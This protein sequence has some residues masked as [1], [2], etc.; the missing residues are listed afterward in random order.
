MTLAIILV[1]LSC[2]LVVCWAGAAGSVWGRYAITQFI[3]GQ[4]LTIHLYVNN[5]TPVYGSAST[6]FT[7]LG[8]SGYAAITLNGGG[9][10][11]TNHVTYDDG[12][13]ANVTFT[14]TPSSSPDVVY[15]YYVLDGSS[16][17]VFGELFSDGPYTFPAMTPASLTIT[18]GVRTTS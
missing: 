5:Y 9:W 4:N 18:P 17:F 14:W 2:Y 12:D 13:Y 7:E 8:S 16:N 11:V 3:N 10:T 6:D 15:G 1:V